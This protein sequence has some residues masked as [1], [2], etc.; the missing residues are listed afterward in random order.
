[1]EERRIALAPSLTA[2]AMRWA[3]TWPSSWGGVSHAISIGMLFA[4]P[5]SLA[6]ASA[7]VRAERKTGFVELFA[8]MPILSRVTAFA[9]GVP[10]GRGLSGR[11]ATVGV[12]PTG[13]AELLPGPIWSPPQAAAARATERAAPRRAFIFVTPEKNAIT[14]RP[15]R[16]G[17]PP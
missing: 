3:W 15:A 6:A 1:D 16:G 11:L 13:L 9:L 8:I 2:W 7:P 12:L 17:A 10:D 4:A 14:R 5:S